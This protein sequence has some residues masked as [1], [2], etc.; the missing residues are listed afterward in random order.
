[1]IPVI[2]ALAGGAIV[3]YILQEAE[4]AIPV[5]VGTVLFIVLLFIWPAAAW[6]LFFGVCIISLVLGLIAYWE[7]ALG[8]VLGVL[9]FVFLVLGL[10]HSTAGYAGAQEEEYQFHSCFKVEECE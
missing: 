8:I 9:M 1:M 7:T 3:S 2:T 5:F 10:L 4:L 6:T